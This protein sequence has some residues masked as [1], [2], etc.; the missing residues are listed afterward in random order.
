[1]KNAFLFF[2]L[3][4]LK[5]FAQTIDTI[6]TK[7]QAKYKARFIHPR[8]KYLAVSGGF[9][10]INTFINDQNSFFNNG[11]TQI[12]N[13]NA[14]FLVY[15]HGIKNNLFA[16]FGYS[17]FES[18]LTVKRMVRD[19][20]FASYAGLTRN[21]QF[22]L[23]G[24]YRIITSKRIHLLNIHSGLFIGFLNDQISDNFQ[25]VDYK[26]VDPTT[27]QEISYNFINKKTER[28]SIGTY[29]SLSKEFRLS[30]QVRFFVKYT[31][32]IGFNN[33][34]E[35]EINLESTSIPFNYNA[36]YRVRNS[37]GL[38][39]FGLKIQLNNKIQ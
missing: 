24:G 39:G 32:Q 23:G 22:Q 11:S 15:E 2:I 13:S 20:G 3:L 1:M 36:K 31:Q 18:G 8:A 4:P 26:N 19:V 38:I 17:F 33:I 5:F 28:I 6:E 14:F 27:S 16:E 37:G 9:S 25:S 7:Q 29:I 30:K 10:Y 21:H 12:N 35:G 34:F